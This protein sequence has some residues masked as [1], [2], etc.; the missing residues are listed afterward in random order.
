M[1][2]PDE[3]F[4]FASY[5]SKD[6]YFVHA[7]IERLKRQGYQVWYDQGELQP[8]RF[9]DLEI[10]QAITA[11]ACFMVFITEDS[12]LSEHVCDEIDQALRENKPFIAIYWDN[13]ELPADLQTL[14]RKRQTLDRYSM[15]QPAYEERLTKALSEHIHHLTLR[16]NPE[17]VPDPSPD[18]TPASN[19]PKIVIFALLAAA[20]IVWF[21]SVLFAISPPLISKSP[22]ELKSN[23]VIGLIMGSTFFLFGLGLIGAA[24][25]VFR[26]YLRRRK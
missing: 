10:R 4:I 14:V 15:H 19:L 8:A 5:S 18:P 26:T 24:F 9:W 6:T 16:P 22:E 23:H 2:L 13:V 17:I 7:E 21:L 12:I 20:G 11:C 25:A 1:S 3:A